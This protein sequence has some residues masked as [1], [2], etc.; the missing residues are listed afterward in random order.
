M[1][2]RAGVT[3]P[4]RSR[5]LRY[6]VVTSA[7]VL[8]VCVVLALVAGPALASSQGRLA[9][10]TERTFG[11]ITG[12]DGH[13]VALDWTPVGGER[14]VDSVALAGAA[15]PVGTRTEVAYDPAR[16]D[17]PLVPGAARLAA[18]DR[19]LSTLV[20]AGTVAVLVLGVGAWQV[21]TRR[22]AAGQPVRPLAVRRVRVQAGMISR[23][24]LETDTT[25]PRWIPVHFDPALAVL[26]S[27]ATLRLRG[28]P[29]RDRLVAVEVDGRILHP[30]GPVRAAEPRGSRVDNPAGPDASAHERAAVLGRLRRQLLAD[31]PLTIPAP[32]VALLWTWVDGGGVAT[33]AAATPLLAALALWFAAIRGS[34]PT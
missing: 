31:L 3:A 12:V 16:L 28:D 15:P 6:G 24:W 5:A 34:D 33:W 32:L 18:A 20:L 30:S 9:A 29:L 23:S 2:A 10:A 21:G 7:L 8:A 1:T 17:A 25:P 19:A 13:E 22:R 26:P 11:T 14:R 27:P 4:H